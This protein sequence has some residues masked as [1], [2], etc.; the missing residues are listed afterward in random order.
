MKNKL[1]MR[2]LNLHK[3]RRILGEAEELSKKEIEWDVPDDLRKN[4]SRTDFWETFISIGKW[5][6]NN[7][8]FL[9][10]STEGKLIYLTKKIIKEI[11][12][13]IK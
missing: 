5:K 3:A 2:K 11:Y 8:K 10:I 6:N 1:R 13:E 12:K 4:I 9:L 7:E